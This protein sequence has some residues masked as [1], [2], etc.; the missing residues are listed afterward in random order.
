[1]SKNSLNA[2]LIQAQNLR[3]WLLLVYPF[4][5]EVEG[6][7]LDLGE[8]EAEAVGLFDLESMPPSHD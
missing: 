1:L 6:R 5:V 4:F 7:F 2:F 3:K 8:E